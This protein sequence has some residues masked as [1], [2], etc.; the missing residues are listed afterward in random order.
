MVDD[1]CTFNF[2]GEGQAPVGWLAN[3]LNE[4]EMQ[5]SLNEMSVPFQILLPHSI[6]SYHNFTSFNAL[7]WLLVG[8]I[9]CQLKT[10]L[11]F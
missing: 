4:S 2:G 10:N 9:A 6:T 11:M 1:R 8:M 5:C 7:I 3:C